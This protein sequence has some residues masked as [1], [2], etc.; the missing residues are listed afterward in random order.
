[1]SPLFPYTTLFRSHFAASFHA[2]SWTPSFLWLLHPCTFD[3]YE[4]ANPEFSELAANT[5]M[6]DP[7]E[8]EPRIAFYRSEEHTSEL[9][10]RFD[11]VCRLLL[12]KKNMENTGSE[13]GRLQG[14]QKHTQIS[15]SQLRMLFIGV[16]VN[17]ANLSV[18]VSTT[19]RGTS[20]LCA[21]ASR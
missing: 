2:G 13:I 9:Q 21:S 17:R 12:E 10:S 19:R 7:S 5:A 15:V 3:I 16:R 1:M 18:M 8:W 11:L 4:F 20:R 14:M 6:F